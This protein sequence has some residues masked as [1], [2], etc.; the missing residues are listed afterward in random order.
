MKNKENVEE[1]EETHHT[2]H[3]LEKFLLLLRVFL[4]SLIMN[5]KNLNFKIIGLVET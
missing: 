2:P 3:V 4:I 5:Q 1:Q